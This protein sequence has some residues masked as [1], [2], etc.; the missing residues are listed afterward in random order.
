MLYNIELPLSTA[1]AIR[2]KLEQ[3]D[4]KQLNSPLN[5]IRYANLIAKLDGIN[6]ELTDLV[7]RTKEEQ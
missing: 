5:A 4:G 3:L 7:N 6:E 1:N 2:I